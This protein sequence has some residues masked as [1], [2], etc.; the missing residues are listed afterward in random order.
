MNVK[1]NQMFGEFKGIVVLENEEVIELE[2]VVGFVERNSA[3]WWEEFI[4]I[5]NVAINV[6]S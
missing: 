4:I 5:K 3:R 2:G 1:L 6:G